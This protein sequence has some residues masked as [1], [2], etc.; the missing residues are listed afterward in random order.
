MTGQTIG[1]GPVVEQ[2]TTARGVGGRWERPLGAAY[3]EMGDVVVGGTA[4]SEELES[5]Q[6]G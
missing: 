3:V 4:W 5:Q 6:G 1:R 2:T